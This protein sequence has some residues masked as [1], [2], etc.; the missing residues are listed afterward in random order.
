MSILAVVNAL[1]FLAPPGISLHYGE[2]PGDIA[3]PWLV[4]NL[5]D[6]DPIE[7]ESQTFATDT[8]TWRITVAAETTGQCLGWAQQV[9][10][11]WRNQRIEVP[12]YS[13]GALRGPTLQGP[14]KAGLTATDTNL[15]YQVAQLRF[16]LTIS[17]I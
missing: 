11:A 6:S 1:K 17:E 5:S 14:Y 15:R 9:A 4:A 2:A 13:I 10:R 8:W 12:G 16:S 7:G 3:A